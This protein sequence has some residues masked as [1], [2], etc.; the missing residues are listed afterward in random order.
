MTRSLLSTTLL[1]CLAVPAIATAQTSRSGLISTNAASRLG[2]TRDW[3]SQVNVDRARGR[4][5]YAT[6]H[7][8]NSHTH[9]LFQVVYD[10]GKLEFS[11][12]SRDR[13]GKQLGPIGAV[14][15]AAERIVEITRDMKA[16][17]GSDTMMDDLTATEQAAEQVLQNI[18]DF[19]SKQETSR[20]EVEVPSVEEFAAPLFNRVKAAPDFLPRFQRRVIP[21]VTLYVATDQGVV[22]AIDGETGKTRWSVPIGRPNH[23]NMA[24][25]A[26][27]KYVAVV[28]GSMLFIVDNQTGK[29]VWER[30]LG[31]APGASP[32]VTEETVFV[33]M[34]SGHLEMY[35]LFR[36]DEE[37]QPARYFVSA[38]RNFL[39]PLTTPNG[40]VCWPTDRGY[41]YVAGGDSNRLRFRL[42]ANKKIESPATF[43]P[44]DLILVSSIDGYV[45]CVKELSGNIIWRFSTGQPISQSPIPIG[46]SVFVVTDEFGL[47]RVDIENG[48]EIWWSPRIRRFLSASATRVY[49]EGDRGQLVVLDLETGGRIGAIDTAGLDLK[50]LNAQTDRIYLGTKKGLIQCLHETSLDLPIVHQAEEARQKPKRAKSDKAVKPDDGVKPAGGG[51]DPFGGGGKDPFGG[52]GADPFGGGAPKGG[53]GSDPFGGGGSD[54]FGGGGSDPFGTP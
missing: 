47:F 52:G 10:G 6:T 3:F 27:D 50:L 21:Q 4:V 11:E 25:A 5:T 33:P 16:R 34:V 40:S 22:H 26:N 31:H 12:L 28:N 13:F 8:N 41:L 45:Y 32:A 37:F 17:E 18:R 7:V 49:C 36:L 44:P 48:K 30:K 2:L 53:G 9:T 38:G 20:E 19:R 43:A 42:E 46:N 54:P 29:T 14:E 23:P 39:P 35:K 24:P 1:L 51:K 15:L